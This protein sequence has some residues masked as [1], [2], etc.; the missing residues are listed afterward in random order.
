ME[1]IISRRQGHQP[2]LIAIG[3]NK[4]AIQDYKVA[5]D[6]KFLDTSSSSVLNAFD[7]LLKVHFVFQTKFDSGLENLYCF[8]QHFFYKIENVVL[9]IK[10]R[11]LRNRLMNYSN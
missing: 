5:I 8:V 9:T 3:P 7:F 10:M 1:E 11:E 4:A 2:Y 6:G